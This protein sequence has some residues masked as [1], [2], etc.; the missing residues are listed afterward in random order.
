M[1]HDQTYSAL[2]PYLM[3]DDGAA[4][5]E[6][7]K[8]AF[9]AEVVETYP[10]E[11]K[12]GHATLRINGSDMMLSDEFPE[13]IAG[14]RTPKSLGGTSV[15]ISLNVDDADVWFERAIAAG[16]TVFRPL[17]DEFYGRSGKLVDPY[18]HSWGILG[19]SKAG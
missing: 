3:V 17:K 18:G 8:N 13:S 10:H 5:I 2:S 6:F 12:L 15:T 1:A 9:N 7:Y 14:V 4:A 19:P 16:A 11:G